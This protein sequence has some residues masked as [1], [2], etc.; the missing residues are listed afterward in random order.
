VSADTYNAR[1]T[2]EQF[3]RFSIDIFAGN[4]TISEYVKA[5]AGDNVRL[6]K[7]IAEQ[8]LTQVESIVTTNMRAGNRPSAI[9]KLLTN[10]F[11]VTKRRAKMIARDQSAKINADLAEKRMRSAGIEHFQWVTSKDQRV[12]DRHDSIANKVTKYGKGIYRWDDL[13]LSD[14]GVPI[15]AGTDFQCFPGDLQ[16]DNTTFCNVMYRRW[17]T[18]ELTELVFGDGVILR[19]TR[20]HPILTDKGFKPAYLINCSDNIVRA[21]D[22]S[23]LAAKLDS[24]G[25]I[26]TFEQIFSAFDLLGVELGVSSSAKGQFH[27]DISDG[28]VNIIELNRLLVDAVNPSIVEKL[29]KLELTDSDK[30][31]IFD[32]FSCFGEGD[33]GSVAFRGSLVSLMSRLNLSI[34]LFLGHFT[35]LECFGLTLGSWFNTELFDV[36][37]DNIS[38]HP[39]MLS[40]CI[41]AF[42]VLVHGNHILAEVVESFLFERVGSLNSKLFNRSL[43]DALGNTKITGYADDRLATSY[44][45]ERVIDNRSI[46]FS[47]HV[48]NLQTV[49]GDYT[50]CSTVVSNC[51]C[52]ARPVLK[53]EVERNQREGRTNPSVKK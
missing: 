37:T 29:N 39:E 32:A 45:I 17:F 22:K 53:S 13:P 40:D 46:C 15:A 3:R 2:Q 24:E 11:G 36:S 16:L 1:K 30:V 50:T 48:Y 33:F 34:S 18:G 20:N 51:R 10:Q 42:S 26:P 14:K 25:V 6:I 41:L 23:F 12:R 19:A 7:S 31:V 44:K 28:D 4:E 21:V 49:S 27:G 52:V 47:G 5:S 43:Y 38:R 8:Y 35:P 9:E